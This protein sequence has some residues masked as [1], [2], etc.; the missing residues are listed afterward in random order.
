M[1]DKKK[2]IEVD[3]F[4][5]V[6]TS[7]LPEDL[8]TGVSQEGESDVSP[9]GA[10]LDP[11]AAFMLLSADAL[12]EW[13]VSVVELLDR[14]DLSDLDSEHR[15]RLMA[16]LDDTPLGDVSNMS[17]SE[18]QELVDSLA[19]DGDLEDDDTSG[20]S[21]LS[22]V[23]FV[24]GGLGRALLPAPVKVVLGLGST[25]WSVFKGVLWGLVVFGGFQL[26]RR[27]GSKVVQPTDGGESV[28]LEW[29]YELVP[30]R[31]VAGSQVITTAG[32]T[33]RVRTG[34]LEGSEILFERLTGA[35]AVGG[36]LSSGYYRSNGAVHG[37]WDLRTP[38]KTPLRWPFDE[39]GKVVRI[40]ESP[41]GGKQI[42]VQTATREWGFAHLSDNS[43]VS[44][45]TVLRR[46]DLFAVSGRSGTPK[47]GG[48]YSPHL[49]VN[50][51][52]LEDLGRSYSSDVERRLGHEDVVSAMRGEGVD[53]PV[54]SLSSEPSTV[55]GGV[56]NQNTILGSPVARRT[57]NPFSVSALPNSQQ[58][59]GQV[60]KERLSSG[61]T[62]AKFD[63]PRSSACAASLT[64]LRYQQ[65]LDLSNTG[66]VSIRLDD[67]A[68][69]YVDG[70][71]QGSSLSVDARR[72]GEG[73]ARRMGRSLQDT[74]DFRKP[75]ELE[76]MLDAVA[77]HESNST[78]SPADRRVAVESA[79]QY[80][81][82]RGYNDQGGG[83]WVPNV[84]R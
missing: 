59:E 55:L 24:F 15:A 31:T 78:I 57:N 18:L 16:Y 32:R 63:S 1:E 79:Y 68:R 45:G 58:W 3:D 40:N 5:S 36:A 66:G 51:T 17:V 39:E 9:S 30:S 76:S 52:K 4:R 73:V 81:L 7:E 62:L 25:I 22:T 38:D 82:D 53:V 48:S 83:V 6:K 71:R 12:Q 35:K 42:F 44:V 77:W 41:S 46:G 14:D 23:G 34:E 2:D 43:V 28:T 75:E 67:I 70:G 61:V 20:D 64:L 13:W 33:L 74:V 26:V 54:S 10:S 11:L 84:Q 50:V 8:Q 80:R 37:A 21:I 47:G 69:Y 27:K 29:D 56:N 60:G 72:W 49:H 65:D 19:V